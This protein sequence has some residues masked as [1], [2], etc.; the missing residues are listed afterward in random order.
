V[1]S[2]MTYSTQVTVREAALETGANLARTGTGTSCLT[3]T[4]VTTLFN[5]AMPTQSQIVTLFNSA[6][7]SLLPPAMNS[8]AGT[9]G[10]PLVQ[11]SW[12]QGSGAATGT[13][14]YL[15]ITTRYS[16]VPPGVRGLAVP[17]SVGETQM[18]EGT[19]GTV[20]ALCG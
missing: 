7:P 4:Q 18:V 12:A 17:L 1:L 14:A 8:G 16:W 15:Q 11:A 19:S 3:Q 6:M 10:A 9:A 13:G 20:A 2:A 5:N